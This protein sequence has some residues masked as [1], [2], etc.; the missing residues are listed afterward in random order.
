MSWIGNDGERE[1]TE[2]SGMVIFVYFFVLSLFEVF[3]GIMEGRGVK[4]KGEKA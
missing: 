4:G 1:R 2:G 3:D